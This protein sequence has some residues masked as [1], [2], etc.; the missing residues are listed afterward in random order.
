MTRSFDLTRRAAL[1]SGVSLVLMARAADADTGLA[2]KKLVVI[3]AR[4][5]MDGLSVSPPIGDAAYAGLRG[6]IAIPADQALKL[7]ADFALHPKLVAVH[8][9]ALRA[10]HAS[11]PRS[12]RPIVPGPILRRRTCSKA[13]WF[14]FIPPAPAG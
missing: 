9:L 3:V 10:K 11:R 14:R 2:K 12:L 6:Q 8:A 1:A 4:G 7:D 5:G 13:A